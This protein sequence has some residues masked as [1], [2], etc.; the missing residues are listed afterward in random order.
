M[1]EKESCVHGKAGPVVAIALLLSACSDPKAA[2]EENFSRALQEYFDL[3]QACLHFPA[4][5]PWTMPLSMIEFTDWEE[6]QQALQEMTRLGFIEEKATESEYE[7]LWQDADYPGETRTEPAVEYS[8]TEKGRQIARPYHDMVEGTQL[9]YGHRQLVEVLDFT[10]PERD[11]HGTLRSRVS[12]HYRIDEVA[13]WA[14][15]SEVLRHLFPPLETDLDAMRR[16][17]QAELVLSL[18]HD[19]WQHDRT[20]ML[21]QMFE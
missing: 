2:N 4:D 14:A 5:L 18:H 8:L 9:C 3:E 13:D 16:P 17:T 1:F 12:Y 7:V 11:F 20:P 19:G 10:V 21:R 15:N 6:Y